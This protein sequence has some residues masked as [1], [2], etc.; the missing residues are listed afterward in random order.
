[1]RIKNEFNSFKMTSKMV[2]LMEIK[3]KN[4]GCFL[5]WESLENRGFSRLSSK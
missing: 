5:K 3:S 4:N 1:M 2:H